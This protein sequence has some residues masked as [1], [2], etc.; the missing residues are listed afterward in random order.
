MFEG[1]FIVF[2]VAF[3]FDCDFDCCFDFLDT[4]PYLSSWVRASSNGKLYRLR[5]LVKITDL[6]AS[7]P[8]GPRCAL[9]VTT[10]G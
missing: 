9:P 8:P 10:Y 2:T 5:H 3:D 7:S 4:A 1:R 6:G